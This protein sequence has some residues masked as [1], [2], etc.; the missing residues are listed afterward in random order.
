M[1]EQLENRV[2][3][4]EIN[5]A[6]KNTELSG[7]LRHIRRILSNGLISEIKEIANKVSELTLSVETKTFGKEEMK[8]LK[9]M[10]DMVK[11]HEREI[12]FIFTAIV[13]CA[14]KVVFFR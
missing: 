3:E 8:E 5:C 6:A 1:N 13:M 11:R 9:K 7:E 4:I 14:I 10:P 2:R 12:W